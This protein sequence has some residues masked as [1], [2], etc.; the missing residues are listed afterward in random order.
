MK[1]KENKN[2]KKALTVAVILFVIVAFLGIMLTIGYTTLQQLE[3][4]KNEAIMRQTESTWEYIYARIAD[5]YEKAKDQSTSIKNNILNDI[6]KE[7]DSRESLIFD[8][9]QV[10][11]GK[12]CK[13]INILGKNISDVYF[14]DIKND[15]NDPFI[16][17]SKRIITDY[18][19]NCSADKRTR[20]LNEE[21]AMHFNK[22]LAT[23]A[24]NTIIERSDKEVF[25]CFESV[26]INFPWYEDIKNIENMDMT[27]LKKIF[28]KYKDV[29]VLSSFEFI[30]TD[31]IYEKTDLIGEPIVNNFG[32]KNNDANQLYINSNFN[33]VDVML[34]NPN[35][36]VVIHAYENS[37]NDLES[38]Y[39][40]KR[41][42]TYLL[43]IVELLAFIISLIA[44]SR[45]QYS[46]LSKE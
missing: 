35:D 1:N 19:M 14:E 4:N 22:Y 16:M 3:R 43:I 38:K 37:I 25:W 44:L 11:K 41:E 36:S 26:N 13:L 40:N 21:I 27:E 9:N 6:R 24:L 5:N 46:I 39:K 18:S 2:K 45:L 29:R 33:I 30:S 15:A 34:N 42:D 7:Y 31:Y 28:L 12:E 20:D 10:V 8:L 17:S 23:Q 32:I